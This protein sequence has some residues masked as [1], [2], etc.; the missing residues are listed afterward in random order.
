MPAIV[1]I[2][3]QGDFTRKGGLAG[4]PVLSSAE[5]PR[6]SLCARAT[7]KHEMH[8]SRAMWEF[9][10]MGAAVASG[11]ASQGRAAGFLEGWRASTSPQLKRELTLLLGTAATS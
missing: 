10:V 8:E 6:S 1:T 2:R 3:C 5:S 7:C 4:P 9:G 11:P